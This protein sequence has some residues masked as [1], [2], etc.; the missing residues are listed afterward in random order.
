MDFESVKK[1]VKDK[2]KR[3]SIEV[4]LWGGTVTLGELSAADKLEL[5]QL[6]GSQGHVDSQI[7]LDAYIFI[8]RRSVLDGSGERMFAMEEGKEFLVHQPL[9]LIQQVAEAAID[10]SGLGEDVDH[11]KKETGETGGSPRET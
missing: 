7:G 11:K 4:P 8:I 10:L 6:P 3:T 5:S 1:S 9:E 2:W